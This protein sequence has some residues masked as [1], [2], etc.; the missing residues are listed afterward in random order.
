[1]LDKKLYRI[2]KFN[3]RYLLLKIAQIIAFS[4]FYRKIQVIGRN[5][6]PHGNPIIFTPNHQNA[7]MDALAILNTCGMNPVFMARADIFRKKRQADMLTFLKILPI[8]RQRDGTE[9]LSKNNEI[10]NLALTILEDKESICLMPE[11][12]HYHQRRLRPLVK[13][14][15]RIAFS[16]QEKFGDKLSVKI[17]PVGIDYVHY[18]N[19]HQDLLINYGHA[20]DVNDFMDQ[21]LE[22]PPR[23]INSIK[24]RLSEELKKLMIHIQ[25]EEYYDTYHELRYLY[26]QRMR[27]RLGIFKK[28]HYHR[29]LADKEMIR[30]MDENFV[31][32]PAEMKTLSSQVIEYS[33]GVKKLK[34]R[35]W[36]FDKKGYS[37][38][39]IV[40]RFICLIIGFPF[41]LAGWL[42]NI[43]PY[44]LPQRMIRN[45]KD[46]QFHASFKFGIVLVLFPAYYIIIAV[47]VAFITGSAWILWIYIACG[48]LSGYFAL[49]YSFW[50]KK[51]RAAI[52]YRRLIKRADPEI[53]N[54]TKLHETIISAMNEMVEEYQKRYIPEN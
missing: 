26:N 8:Y 16:A 2:H 6:I 50:F 36:V 9:E 34:L 54:L 49:Y 46:P 31:K 51:L 27:N 38:S 14:S 24:D 39:G 20:I 7:L 10:F 33:E 15:F 42:N 41:F 23:A 43:I 18:Q 45:V 40:T 30:I 21:Y 19:I 22:N 53:I 29:F 3:F 25:N 37:F 11:G 47:I 1:M 52:K 44:K 35:N 12:N 32:N 17:M 5:N 28:T 48:V 4:A 13:G